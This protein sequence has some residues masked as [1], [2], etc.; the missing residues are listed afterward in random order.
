MKVF[1]VIT[2]L[3]VFLQAQ[4]VGIGTEN[5]AA[6]L[7]VNHN[8]T[9]G[10][11]LQIL[12][13]S[14]VFAGSVRFRNINRTASMH[15][16]GYSADNL[17]TNQYLDI[18]SD[19]AF[20]ATFR[21]DGRVGIRNNNPLYSLDITGD[22]NFTGALRINGNA[23]T[24]GQV[25]FSTG[26][27]AVSWKNPLPGGSVIFSGTENDPDFISAGYTMMGK[28]E[29]YN[30]KAYAGENSGTWTQNTLTANAPLGRFG[31]VAVWTGTEMIIWGG[32]N[33]D[34][35]NGYPTS[36][37]FTAIFKYNPATNNWTR[38]TSFNGTP[39]SNTRKNATAVWTGTEMI[40]WGGEY[41]NG[42]SVFTYDNGYRY[43]PTTNTWTLLTGTGTAPGARSGHSAVWTGTEMLV[44]G[45]SSAIGAKYH[46]ATD[47][48]TAMPI[49]PSFVTGQC[50]AWTGTEMIIWGGI[51]IGSNGLRGKFNPVTNSWS[52]PSTPANSYASNIQGSSAVW[53]GS[54]MLMWGDYATG[55]TYNPATHSCTA[56]GNTPG[57]LH[58]LD[59]TAVW[60]GT[61]MI[62][63]GGKHTYL[64]WAEGNAENTLWRFQFTG[65]S[66]SY[67][68]YGVFPV[69]IYEK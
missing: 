2:F 13:S 60:T 49:G 53:T 42:S 14:A 35:S 55:G 48:W 54:L 4:N 27:G 21:G 46:N 64:P 33:Q 7:Q 25:L 11:G 26:G 15:M 36:A 29:M 68:G 23:G 28:S 31:H 1:A 6:R 19:S 47:T 10:Y 12:D 24:N 67:N 3:P 41:H 22:V 9:T 65:T 32:T 5:P 52:F 61:Q 34:G 63:F 8:S 58:T 44:W 43:N 16:T 69:Y 30:Y 40:I 17:H 45:G 66:K 56:I 38:I 18:A 57:P 20:V 39:P 51:G 59:N 50:A 62:V 37:D